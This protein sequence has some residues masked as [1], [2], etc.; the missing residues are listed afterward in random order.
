MF[1]RVEAGRCMVDWVDP[2]MMVERVILWL[3]RRIGGW[4]CRWKM[5]G[6]V[7]ER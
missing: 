3:V 5:G 4:D 1:W 7:G 2:G 6:W